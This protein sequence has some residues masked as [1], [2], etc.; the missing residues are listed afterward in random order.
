MALHKDHGEERSR[1]AYAQEV[2]QSSYNWYRQAAIKS[3]RFHRL[4]AVS[5]QVIGAAIPVSAAVAPRNSIILAV[6][7]AMIVVVGGLRST[8][9][10]HES[11]IRF[12]R[13]REVVEA[14]R[15]LYA[16]AAFPYDDPATRDQELVAA[17]TRIEQEEMGAW[18]KIVSRQPGPS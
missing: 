3:R 7:G 15:R 16:T 11:Y 13:A 4:T 8:F 6:F 9:N 18:F 12:S 2:A 10:W 1:S 14:E 17:V 5:V